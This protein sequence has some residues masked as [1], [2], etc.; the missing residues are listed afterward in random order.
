M[1]VHKTAAGSAELQRNSSS[2]ELLSGSN[3]KEMIPKKTAKV[4]NHDTHS[5]STKCVAGDDNK[6]Q[7]VAKVSKEHEPKEHSEKRSIRGVPNV[8]T[9]REPNDDVHVNALENVTEKFNKHNLDDENFACSDQLVE[10]PQEDEAK[11]GI[12]LGPKHTEQDAVTKLMQL[13]H[14]KVIEMNECRVEEAK[15]G[16]VASQFPFERILKDITWIGH[17]QNEKKEKGPKMVLKIDFLSSG[18]VKGTVGME[19]GGK[20]SSLEGFWCVP[21]PHDSP[22]VVHIMWLQSEDNSTVLVDGTLAVKAYKKDLAFDASIEGTYQEHDG[23]NMIEGTVCF[24]SNTPPTH[25]RVDKAVAPMKTRAPK[26]STAQL[27]LNAH[28]H[29][30]VQVKGIPGATVDSWGR[31]TLANGYVLKPPPHRS[32]P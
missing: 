31:I 30:A 18:T 32:H 23:R 24:D 3:L 10:K 14:N 4:H 27:D 16:V 17:F 19:N 28:T 21:S 6:C 1:S 20:R 25:K 9:D 29:T 13:Y 5:F 7:Q 11:A 22:K 26:Q 8:H 15:S 12:E 2:P